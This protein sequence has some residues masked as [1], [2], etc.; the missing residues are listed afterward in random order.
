MTI[1][2]LKHGK[3]EAD[4]AE[5]DARGRGIVAISEPPSSSIVDGPRSD[6]GKGRL[7]GRRAVGLVADATDRGRPRPGSRMAPPAPPIPAS[8]GR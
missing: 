6:E 1:I 4:R 3:P 7:R 8:A 5:D 2:H